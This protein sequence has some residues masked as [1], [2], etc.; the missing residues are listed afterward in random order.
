MKRRRIEYDAEGDVVDWEERKL[1][2]EAAGM[3]YPEACRS[4]ELDAADF[5][6][7]F[8]IGCDMVNVSGKRKG[9]RRG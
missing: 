8:L 1:W 7:D 3:L 5:Y 9:G 4:G 2:Q 6:W